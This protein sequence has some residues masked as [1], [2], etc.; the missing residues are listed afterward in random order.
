MSPLVARACAGLEGSAE[1]PW[2]E[3]AV[4]LAVRT[5]RLMAALEADHRDVPPHAV[6]RV[7]R[8]VRTIE[9]LPDAGLT[10]GSLAREAGLSPYHFL[11]TFERLTGV[12]P[13]QFILRMRLRHAAMRLAMEPE[14]VI[15]IAF[16]CGFRDVS[17]FNRAFRAEFGVNPSLYRRSWDRSGEERAA[18]LRMGH[19]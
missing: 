11:R 15:D 8:A 14:R 6:G 13:H 10:L 3:I 9:R 7:T 16:D 5:V 2:E 18:A 12:T 1:V 17:N 4:E 19:P